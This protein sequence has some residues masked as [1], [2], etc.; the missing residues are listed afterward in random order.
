[1]IWINR[2][3]LEKAL[4]ESREDQSE[5]NNFVEEKLK[6]T[7][8]DLDEIELDMSG[9]SW[10]FILQDIIR[11]SPTLQYVSVLSAFT[12]SRMRADGFGGMA[13]FVTADGIKGFSTSDFL[14]DCQGELESK[15]K[16]E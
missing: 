10:E 3:E 15:G 6:D 13:V 16:G 7:E 14:S 5:M 9:T 8:S 1:M 11:R 4:A 2:P 12:C